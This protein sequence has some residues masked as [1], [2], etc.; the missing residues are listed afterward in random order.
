MASQ[1]PHPHRAVPGAG[2]QGEPGR[3]HRDLRD[4]VVVTRQLAQLGPGDV[5]H[6][7]GGVVTGG[8]EQPLSRA[9]SK[10]F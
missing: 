2:H 8:Q 5:P 10:Y 6:V 9:E 4:P 7:D 3:R 1:S